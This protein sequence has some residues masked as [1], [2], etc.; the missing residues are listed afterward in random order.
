MSV[1]P[2]RRLRCGQVW[3]FWPWEKIMDDRHS[4]ARLTRDA[5]PKISSLYIIVEPAKA[6]N[7]M[8]S[9]NPMGR[10]MPPHEG[11]L[12][13]SKMLR[14]IFSLMLLA[15]CHCSQW[16][17]LRWMHVTCS[18]KC[19]ASRSFTKCFPTNPSFRC[20]LSTAKL[21]QKCQPSKTSE[22]S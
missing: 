14:T 12:E 15:D 9:Q 21:K 6:I 2:L 19:A 16:N 10:W 1:N 20:S 5:F 8:V 17:L 22:G 4:K 18:I 3:G 13:E 11:T 7:P